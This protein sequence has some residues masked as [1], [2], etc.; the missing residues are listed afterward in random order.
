MIWWTVKKSPWY[1]FEP[2]I[3][4]LSH[5]LNLVQVQPCT[6]VGRQAPGWTLN[7]GHLL[8]P[9]QG[10]NV[11][12]D[13]AWSGSPTHLRVGE[14]DQM[15]PGPQS[16]GQTK[17]TI[18]MFI[19]MGRTWRIISVK[20][21]CLLIS[22]IE[23]SYHVTHLSLQRSHALPCRHDKVIF[24]RDKM[25]KVGELSSRWAKL[26]FLMS[27]SNFAWHQVALPA[28]VTVSSWEMVG[29]DYDAPSLRLPD[30]IDCLF[31]Q[32]DCIY[33]GSSSQ[34]WGK[35]DFWE[36]HRWSFGWGHWSALHGVTLMMILISDG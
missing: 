29:H 33:Q 13:E 34:W 31:V 5:A 1:D 2:S 24:P 26:L 27:A 9:D 32:R 14:P 15:G 21:F 36:Q 35:D 11:H 25:F 18:T 12:H 7:P 17:V 16:W 20:Q 6:W 30:F 3:K 28:E 10:D 8:G 19:M 22:P 4:T 23:F